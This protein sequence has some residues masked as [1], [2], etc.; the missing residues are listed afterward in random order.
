MTL[1]RSR[2][3]SAAALTTVVLGL[4]LLGGCGGT[5]VGAPAAGRPSVVTSI[6]P[7]QFVAERVVGDHATV[8]DL[9]HPGQEPHDIELD[10]RQVASVADAD[11][12]LYE[13]GFQQP[14]DQAVT[15]DG[16][17]HVVDASVSGRVLGDDPHFWQ[18]PVR[19]RRVTAAFTAEMAAVDPRD[20]A[21]YRRHGRRLERQL[22]ALDRE[23]R[24]GLRH[25]SLR[26]IVVSHDAF[27]YLGRRYALR[28]LG[29]NG[30]SPE[31]EP[32]PWH[33]R[34]LQ[35]T[36]RRLGIS[37][38]Y[39]DPLD[40]SAIAASVADDLGLPTTDLDAVEG[41]TAATAHDNYLTLMRA[42]LRA[43]RR[44]NQCR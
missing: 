2:R 7:L 1:M 37:T 6:Y 30:I 10:A 27:A 21:A 14:V 24:T 32:S 17:P 15:Q 43:L 41:L 22:T 34:Q 20:G 23:Y 38:I 26:T 29:I 5:S 8:E 25:C 12:V 39:G 33:I 16:P 35:D 44:G 28:V 40:S 31:A 3:V 9:T 19:L 4:P 42:N 13:G 36:V 11:V 18:D